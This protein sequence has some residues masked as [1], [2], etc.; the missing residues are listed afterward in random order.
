M[1]QWDIL[2]G[3]LI[4][5]FQRNVVFAFRKFLKRCRKQC[6]LISVWTNYR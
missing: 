4:A 3:H 1:I 6:T 2:R 5:K